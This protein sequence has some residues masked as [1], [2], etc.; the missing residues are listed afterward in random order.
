MKQ[1]LKIS[2]AENSFEET[3]TG[4]GKVKIIEVGN[5]VDLFK[6]LYKLARIVDE[7]PHADETARMMAMCILE[8][9]KAISPA[10]NR[11]YGWRNR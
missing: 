7:T 2:I 11:D 4:Q 8:I 10:S 1:D 5:C 6:T 3:I 9:K